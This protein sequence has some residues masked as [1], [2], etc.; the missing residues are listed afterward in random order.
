MNPHKHSHPHPHHH[1]GHPDGEHGPKRRGRRWLVGAAL[2]LAAGAMSLAG[3][4]FAG[5]GRGMHGHRGHLAAMDPADAA[6]HIDRMVE[7]LLSDGTAEQKA[8]LSAVAKAAFADVQP[9]HREHKASREK[10]RTLLSAPTIDRVALE[11]LRVDEVQR[12]DH[13]SKRI[14]E[15]VADAADVLTPEQRV[16][17]A[18]HMKKRMQ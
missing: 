15:A 5:E 3:A 13:V 12:L 7:H 6:K 16:R 1:H 11:Q 17:F 2:G 18:A 8:R 9:M 10:A 14:L 4:S